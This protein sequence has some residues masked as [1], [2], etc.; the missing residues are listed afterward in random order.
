MS[1]SSIPSS[2]PSQSPI[3][4]KGSATVR[5]ISTGEQIPI[6]IIK[7]D[8][9][10]G[11][12]SFKAITKSGEELGFV[13]CDWYRTKEN[14]VYGSE[15]YPEVTIHDQFFK[16][17][18][19]EKTNHIVIKTI[20][21]CSQKIFKGVGSA[22]LQSVIEYGYSFGCEGRVQL[23]AVLNSHGFYY[24]MGMRTGLKE[25]DEI[26][27]E[28]TKSLQVGEVPGELRPEI[29]HM[30]QKGIDRWSE[31]IDANPIFKE[32]PEPQPVHSNEIGYCPI[33]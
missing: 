17:G 9:S 33:L 29:M 26:I 10:L 24:K 30:P 14:G 15:D 31:Q 25:I 13:H 8:Y 3:Y 12:F 11:E 7:E 27:E 19:S 21:S 5:N 2:H 16:Y 1:A 28:H 32:K 22:L 4:N 18:N 6:K 23:D 20:D